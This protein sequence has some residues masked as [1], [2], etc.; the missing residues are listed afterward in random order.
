MAQAFDMGIDGARVA[1]EIIAP[2]AGENLFAVE[3]APRMA[4][5]Q[6]EQLDLTRR[7]GDALPPSLTL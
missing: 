6:I 7:A 1:E 4:G 2:D 5:K 3:Y